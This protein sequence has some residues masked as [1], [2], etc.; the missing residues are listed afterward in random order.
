MVSRV[1]APVVALLALA[2]LAPVVRAQETP[3]YGG[4]LVF[5]VPAESPSFDALRTAASGRVLA[6][7]WSSARGGRTWTFILRRGVKFH[8]GSELAA[9]DVKASST[10]GGRSDS[11]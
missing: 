7:S 5:V 8:D 10:S 4:E 11:P 3:R 1:A 9:R 6:Q 2:V